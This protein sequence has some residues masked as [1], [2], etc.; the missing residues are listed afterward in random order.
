MPGGIS[1]VR[2]HEGRILHNLML[3][4]EVVFLYVA[5]IPVRR[6]ANL[7]RK[8]W[9]STAIQ[10]TK[11]RTL[12]GSSGHI[13]RIWVRLAGVRESGRSG[14]AG[15]KVVADVARRWN[16]GRIAKRSGR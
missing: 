8:C 3:D 9:P 11:S 13:E 7:Q 6:H 5:L 14:Q 10:R 12:L 4:T 16:R 2:D 15:S 1:D